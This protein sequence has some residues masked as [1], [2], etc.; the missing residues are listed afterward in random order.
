MKLEENR[1]GEFGVFDATNQNTRVRDNLAG[2][3]AVVTNNT[4]SGDPGS[5]GITS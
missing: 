3:E 1:T 4:R 2:W 5:G